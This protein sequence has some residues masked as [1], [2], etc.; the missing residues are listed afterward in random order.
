MARHLHGR[1]ERRRRVRA[2]A[3]DL[4]TGLETFG[5]ACEQH[6]HVFDRAGLVLDSAVVELKAVPYPGSARDVLVFREAL[7]VV[8]LGGCA[9]QERCY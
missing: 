4:L 1:D 5:A 2:L 7:L 8:F 6:A 9:G 3:V